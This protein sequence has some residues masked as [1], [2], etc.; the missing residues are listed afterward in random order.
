MS[1]AGGE[2]SGLWKNPFVLTAS[3]S[4]TADFHKSHKVKPENNHTRVDLLEKEEGDKV[5]FSISSVGEPR[6]Q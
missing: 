5:I 3:K 6:G 4:E 2:E 1:S